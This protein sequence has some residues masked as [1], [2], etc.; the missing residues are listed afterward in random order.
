LG[1]LLDE[2][3]KGCC[4][5]CHEEAVWDEIKEAVDIIEDIDE[6]WHRHH[7][8]RGD[9]GQDHDQRDDNPGHHYR[10]VHPGIN[11]TGR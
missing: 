5:R 3:E 11:V 9:H 6:I 7:E 1:C 2:L 4:D 10:D 8:Y